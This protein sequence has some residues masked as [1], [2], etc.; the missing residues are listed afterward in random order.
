M[1]TPISPYIHGMVG[2]PSFNGGPLSWF[3]SRGQVGVG[4]STVEK[5]NVDI[6]MSVLRRNLKM[7]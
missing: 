6:M 7:N 3:T 5:Q 4:Y 1:S 2:R